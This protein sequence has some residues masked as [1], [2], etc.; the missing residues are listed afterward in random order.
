MLMRPLGR[1]GLSVSALGLGTAK[2]GRTQGLKYRHPFALP[3]D[4]QV[5]D[6]LATA[7]ALG[8]NLLDTAPAYG[9][10]EERLGEA[11]ADSRADWVICTKAGETFDG[12][13][14]RY[15]FR[16]SALMG[17]VERSLQRLRTDVLDIVLLHSDGR[18]VAALEEAGAFQA[19]RRLQRQGTVRC[20]GISAKNAR[21]SAA[22]MPHC[23]V[24]MCTVNPRCR[25]AV[26]VCAEAQRRGIGVLVKKPLASGFEPV[27]TLAATGAVVGVSSIVLGTM[28][29]GHLRAAARMLGGCDS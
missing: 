27:T 5:A 11:I 29:A 3:S 16:E 18:N 7:K 17:S 4:E 9:L 14:S 19:L 2:L 25:S 13:A 15:D 22:A 8:I 12:A 23:D 6:L 21:D 26:P 24:L 10:S 28:Q 1:T 20:V